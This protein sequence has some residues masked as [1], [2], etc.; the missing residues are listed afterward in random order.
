MFMTTRLRKAMLTSH[1]TFSIGWLGAV[2][3]FLVLAIT[4]LTSKDS[5]LVRSS[6]LAMKLSAWFVIVPF[7][8]TSLLTGVVQA[9]GTKWGLFRYYWIIIKLFLTIASTALLLLHLRPIN[10]LAAE[11]AGASFSNVQQADAIINLIAK[12]GAAMLVLLFITTISVYKPWGKIQW[13][14][15]ND[16]GAGTDNSA[17]NKKSWKLYAVIALISLLLLVIIKHLLSGG[18]HGH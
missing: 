4:G 15:G 6:L 18:M 9:A 13:V 7:C 3:V 2:V 8:L 5:Q 17:A 10:Y 11:A 1:I 16:K 12:S 14:Q